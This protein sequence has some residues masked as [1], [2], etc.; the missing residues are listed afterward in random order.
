MQDV[1]DFELRA[2]VAENMIFPLYRHAIAA[3]ISPIFLVAICRRLLR[4]SVD[5]NVGR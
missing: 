3:V 2:L 1:N 4:L 5:A